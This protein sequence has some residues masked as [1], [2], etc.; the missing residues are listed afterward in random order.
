M[1]KILLHHIYRKSK[2]LLLCDN[3]EGVDLLLRV[4]PHQFSNVHILVTTRCCT[5]NKLPQ[6]ADHVITLQYLLGDN[7]LTTLFGWA[8]TSH[9]VD[10]YE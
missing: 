7:A 2:V 4:L 5:D 1:N 3:V 8:E 9:P 10:E 6:K